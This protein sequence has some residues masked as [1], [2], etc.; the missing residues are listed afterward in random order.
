MLVGVL[1]ATVLLVRR[2]DRDAQPAVADLLTCL[3]VVVCVVHQP[4]D[5]LIAVP[6]MAAVAALCWQRRHDRSWRTAGVAV[7]ALAIPFAHLYAVDTAIASV[8]GA[9]VAV[10]V[11]GVAVVVAWALLVVFSVRL[12]RAPRPAMVTG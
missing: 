6:A 9:R 1:A 11:D 3:A 4:G 7:L 8:L 10:T 2:L 5:V 12:V